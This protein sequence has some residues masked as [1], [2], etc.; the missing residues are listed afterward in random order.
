[1]LERAVKL[2]GTSFRDYLDIE[3]R[4]GDFAAQLR[5]YQREGEPCARCRRPICRLV[6]AGRSSHFCPK[7]QPRPAYARSSASVMTVAAHAVRSKR[8]S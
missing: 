7:C 8:R 4:P 6:I 3:G 2:Q 5:V 1:V